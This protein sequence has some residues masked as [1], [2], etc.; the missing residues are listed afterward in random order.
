MINKDLVH[1][2][3]GM[4]QVTKNHHILT[5]SVPIVGKMVTQSLD[6]LKDKP[7]NIEK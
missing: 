4:T 6:V 1:R 5:N 3:S 2:T 7:L